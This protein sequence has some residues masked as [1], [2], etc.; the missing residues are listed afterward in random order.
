MQAKS[1]EI[2]NSANAFQRDSTALRKEI[3]AIGFKK[4]TAVLFAATSP[5]SF[6]SR[7]LR[8]AVGKIRENRREE[9]T[10]K[11][12]NWDCDQENGTIRG[13]HK[14]SQNHGNPF[15]NDDVSESILRVCAGFFERNKKFHPISFESN[16]RLI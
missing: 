5:M 14:K 2:W 15:A 1:E 7:R 11:T 16:S 13:V 8:N 4:E 10:V 3:R 12:F 6:I 9:K